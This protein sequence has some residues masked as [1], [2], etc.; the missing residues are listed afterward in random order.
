MINYCDKCASIRTMPI[1]KVQ[2][3]LTC[4]LCGNTSLC[5]TDKIG[6]LSSPAD[7]FSEKGYFNSKDLSGL[8]ALIKSRKAV[9]ASRIKQLQTEIS[10]PMQIATIADDIDDIHSLV[11]LGVQKRS[12]PSAIATFKKIQAI[13]QRWSFSGHRETKVVVLQNLLAEQAGLDEKEKELSILFKNALDQIL[14]QR[15]R[16]RVGPAAFDKCYNEAKDIYSKQNKKG[17]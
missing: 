5:S 7:A 9:V 2:S 12:L 3:K 1:S 6:V 16:F 17:V 13:I 15:L 10:K 4:D 11:G 14:I 8:L